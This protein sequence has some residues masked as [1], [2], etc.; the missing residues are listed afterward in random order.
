MSVFYVN[1]Y[2][3][4]IG[5]NVPM[6]ACIPFE[7]PN[8]FENGGFKS[9]YLL[10]GLHG[11]ESNWIQKTNI[12]ELSAKYNIA[13]FMPA[14]ENSFYLNNPKRMTNFSTYIGVELVE[15]TR[16]VFNLST[17]REDTFIGGLSMGGYGA[18]I[19]G[20]KYPETFGGIIAFSPVWSKYC[21]TIFV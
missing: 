21:P 17:K 2:S 9:L 16:K 1:F 7:N 20:L 4:A 6:V 14:G 8:C 19:N 5:R 13:V 10:H 12:E 18:T 11:N 15:Y 3:K